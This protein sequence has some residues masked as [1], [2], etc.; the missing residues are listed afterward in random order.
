MADEYST[1]AGRMKALDKKTH[2]QI[3]A[4]SK[5]GDE[6]ARN[7]KLD[8]A[9]KKFTAAWQLIPKDKEN[10]EASTWLLVSAADIHFGRGALEKARQ[11]L[12]EALECP[13]GLGNPYVHLR[14]GEIEFE[15]GNKKAAGDQLARAYMG[16]GRDI[17]KE[18]DPKYLAF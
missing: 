16:A 15:L 7:G 3:E 8:E 12:M 5:E 10:W 13:G 4:L 1:G 14:L 9:L 17:F 18:E 2:A 6:L 11:M